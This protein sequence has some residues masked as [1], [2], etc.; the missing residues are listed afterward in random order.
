MKRL[1]FFITLFYISG[2]QAA[3]KVPEPNF[4]LANHADKEIHFAVV[5]A[6]DVLTIRNLELVSPTITTLQPGEEYYETISLHGEL[7][8]KPPLLYVYPNPNEEQ[9]RLPLAIDISRDNVHTV[10]ENLVGDE[11]IYKL[12]KGKPLF[13][14]IAPGHEYHKHGKPATDYY[15]GLTVKSL[16]GDRD[17]FYR[18][19]VYVSGITRTKDIKRAWGY[20]V[21]GRWAYHNR[22]EFAEFLEAVDIFLYTYLR[23]GN[24]VKYI[25]RYG[26]VKGAK[27]ISRVRALKAKM[28]RR[29]KMKF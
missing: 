2:L 20:E 23:A 8:D 14:E 6:N 7:D 27:D 26:L 3:E 4:Y 5:C 21:L 19:G 24:I 13:L 15:E 28:E 12:G 9:E 18:N 25:W 17:D 29:I 1:F 16:S 22:E 11:R 10:V